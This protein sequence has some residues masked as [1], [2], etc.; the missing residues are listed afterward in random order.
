[1][2]LEVELR[3][4][5][6]VSPTASASPQQLSVLLLGP[7]S[8]VLNDSSIRQ[9]NV[10]SNKVVHCH[11]KLAAEKASATRKRQTA[12]AS[13][14]IGPNWHKPAMGSTFSIN[15]GEN[16]SCLGTHFLSLRIVL[17]SFQL[18]HVNGEGTINEAIGRVA[19]CGHADLQSIGCCELEACSDVSGSA[20]LDDD[21]GESQEILVPHPIYPMGVVAGCEFPGVKAVLVVLCSWQTGA[22]INSCNFRPTGETLLECLEIVLLLEEVLLR[23]LQSFQTR[24]LNLLI[25]PLSCSNCCGCILATLGKSCTTH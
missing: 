22:L 1:M 25:A 2:G 13:V 19:T 24:C 10:N 5:T 14:A 18:C 21:M 7:I 23:L 3:H 4:N 20:D 6:K 12:N 9:H 16:S 11:A 17:G 8:D 15:G